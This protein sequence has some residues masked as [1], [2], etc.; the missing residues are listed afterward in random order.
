MLLPQH[1]SR[2]GWVVSPVRMLPCNEPERKTYVAGDQG[3]W[4][5]LPNKSWA[6]KISRWLRFGIPSRRPGTTPSWP[7]GQACSKW[8]GPD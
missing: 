6:R 8:P 3:L 7:R 5:Q 1:A 4:D 2:D